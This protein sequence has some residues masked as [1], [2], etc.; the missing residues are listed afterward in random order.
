[1][2]PLL[3]SAL[4][5]F[6]CATIGAVPAC[7]QQSLSADQQIQQGLLYGRQGQFS[8]A[9]GSFEKAIKLNANNPEAHYNYALAMLAEKRQVPSW[10]DALVHFQAALALRPNYA[11]A[12]NMIAVCHLEMGEPALA[13][14]FIEQAIQ[15][16]PAM[17][18]AYF[19][20][21]RILEA[22]DHNEQALLQYR[23]AIA[24]QSAYPAALDAAGKLALNA[25]D[26]KSSEADFTA[27][28]RLNADQQEAHY[29]L[30][31]SLRA[32]GK[33]RQAQI[34]LKISAALL[35][36]KSNAIMSNHLSNEALDVAKAGDAKSA[37][38]KLRSAL[39]LDPSN[40][41]ANY[42]MALVLADM[43]QCPAALHQIQKA[44]SLDP[45]KVEFQHARARIF[46][47]CATT[48]GS[49][50]TDKALAGKGLSASLAASSSHAVQDS[51][52]TADSIS[53]SPDDHAQYAE[54][55]SL[56][57]DFIGACGELLRAVEI[58][59]S[60]ADLRVKLAI[61]RAQS[62]DSEGAE[63]EFHKALLQAPQ[64]A[65]IYFSLA[66]L[67]MSTNHLPEA[68]EAFEKVLELEPNHAA[69]K[70]S[71]QFLAKKNSAQ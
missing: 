6:L 20:Y 50:Q 66:Q 15:L 71:L 62:A 10:Q 41:L 57:G 18:Q 29:M 61:A 60:R 43:H 33:T 22:L 37:I 3:L 48:A 17:A 2:K 36:Q 68:T 53:E 30:A 65:Q 35:K 31:R 38:E 40:A 14:P 49:Q 34:E 28:L 39:W 59:P 24:H 64:S 8:L 12:L 27:S 1:M 51:Q 16:A 55:L 45:A 32:L 56:Q 63:L 5:L 54:Q 25:G 21:G 19:N 44:L 58:A 9:R 70:A 67:L 69:A 42:N 47:A 52:L 4:S 11:E 23:A 7:T 26:F 46:S 13:Q